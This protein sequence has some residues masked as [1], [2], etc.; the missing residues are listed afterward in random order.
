MVVQLEI[1]AVV[2]VLVAI[3]AIIRVR[4][5]ALIFAAN[6]ALAARAMANVAQ[7]GQPES[8]SFL[9]GNV[10][11]TDNIEIARTVLVLSVGCSL[12]FV[13]AG[14][15]TAR[16]TLV[17]PKL[18]FYNV[19]YG[20]IALYLV[21]LVLA[22]K[23][24]A[25]NDYTDPNR[26]FAVVSLG[27]GH[28]LVVGLVLCEFYRRICIKQLK[29]HRAFLLLLGLCVLTDF[30]KGATGMAT[31][32]LVTGAVLFLGHGRTP[33][34]RAAMILSAVILIVTL[35]ALVRG[36]RESL[37]EE[38]VSSVSTFVSSLSPTQS[39]ESRT[40]EGMERVGMPP[41]RPLI[42]SSASP[43]TSPE[44]PESGSLSTIRRSTPLSLLFFCSRWGL[45]VHRRRPGVGRPFYPWRR[46]QCLGR[47]LLEWRIP[48]R[49]RRLLCLEPSH[50]FRGHTLPY[51]L[52]VADAPLLL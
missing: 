7:Y 52:A 21:T 18:P 50:L 10:F 33:V 22:S 11:S 45:L 25:Q 15:P 36:I 27:G 43:S 47:V 20:M 49:S 1:L 12:A 28:A 39:D 6:N 38:G 23:T 26:T 51:E 3:L 16:R 35:S 41:R 13:L 46:Y 24:I 14:R 31:G 2:S 30:V 32:I 19:I 34:R 17:P 44:A 4:P 5:G 48:L 29:P 42:S 9:P 40:G 37:A 8:Q